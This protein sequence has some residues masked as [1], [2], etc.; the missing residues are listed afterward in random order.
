MQKKGEIARRISD[1]ELIALYC[2]T[3][4]EIEAHSKSNYLNLLLAD[5]ANELLQQRLFAIAKLIQVY[6]G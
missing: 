3:E 6:V 4:D 1:A 2:R 5:F